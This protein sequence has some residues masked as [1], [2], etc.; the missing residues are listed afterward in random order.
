MT[1]I[2]ADD[3]PQ[4]PDAGVG[5]AAPP[6]SPRAGEAAP[7][8]GAVPVEIPVTV[9]P[10][11]P[12][13]A[14]VLADPEGNPGAVGAVAATST[15]AAAAPST[16]AAAPPAAAPGTPAAPAPA[17]PATAASPAPPLP[18]VGSPPDDIAV[19]SA[20]ALPGEHRGGFKRAL[21]EPL[22]MT[23][24]IRPEVQWA[25]PP[26]AP[27]PTSAGWALGLSILGLLVSTFI[28]WGFVI[29]L[30]GI[31]LAI[32]ALRRPWESKAMAVWALCLGLL[33]L[34]YSAGWLWWATTQL[35]L[36]G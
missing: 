19:E 27:L 18:D 32:V 16:T 15:P 11:T 35:R 22:P 3:E 26:P 36:A 2:G 33:S 25:P 4:A 8:A 6:R 21:T 31:V 14:A 20:A 29:G 13:D 23:Q 28:G 10:V 30:A 17:T 34:A 1:G 5:P 7:D 12:A 9:D 24:P